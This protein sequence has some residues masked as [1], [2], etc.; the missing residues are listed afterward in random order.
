MRA[1]LQVF[2]MQ[3]EMETAVGA[4]KA[5]G[6]FLR[7]GLG[8]DKNVQHKGEINLV[9]KMDRES[10]DTIIRII[11]EAFPDDD[12]LAEEGSTERRGTARL[13]VVD[14]LDGTTNYAHNY[15]VFAVSIAL[16]VEGEAVVGAVY[17]P[18]RD[19]LF[20]AKKGR[21][22]RLGREPI[23]VS[24]SS[25]VDKSLL[26]TGFPYNLRRE[27]GNLLEHFERF[28]LRAQAVRRDGSAALNLCYVAAGRFD[29]F[30]ETG[31]YP[32]DLVAGALIIQEAGGQVTDYYGRPFDPF[33]GE[34]LASNG[35][36]HMEMMEI[37]ED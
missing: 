4:C 11:S 10:E 31:L 25:C 24:S 3:A 13:W 26:A 23:R 6:A 27:P 17:D 1:A 36:I 12:I 22:A 34:I 2:Y 29:G 5:A 19:E 32:W 30:W 8:R 35:L 7:E 9:T 37:L 15:P 16:L 28:L 14:P 20:T 18:M 21:G 33:R